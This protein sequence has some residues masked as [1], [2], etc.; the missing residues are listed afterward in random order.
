MIYKEYGRAI[1]MTE[2]RVDSV[3]KEYALGS[4]TI[5]NQAKIGKAR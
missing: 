1:G 3:I 4:T 2:T 5:Y